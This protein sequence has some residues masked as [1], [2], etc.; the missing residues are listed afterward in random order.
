MKKYQWDY[1]PCH[2]WRCKPLQCQYQKRIR[3]KKRRRETRQ[4]PSKHGEAIEMRKRRQTGRGSGSE[5]RKSDRRKWT[6]L[7]LSEKVFILLCVKTDS[8]RN[9]CFKIAASWHEIKYLWIPNHLATE[10]ILR[11]KLKILSFFPLSYMN[12][13]EA[14][15][16]M[17]LNRGSKNKLMQ[18]RV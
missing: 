1:Y 7:K 13:I 17:S 9:A 12:F 10:Y 14:K 11:L 15:R 3:R 5:R 16:Y 2:P 4:Y 8:V 18:E 6:G